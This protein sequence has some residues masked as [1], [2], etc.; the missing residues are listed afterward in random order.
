MLACEQ[1]SDNLK[2]P[3]CGSHYKGQCGS[4]TRATEVIRSVLVASAALSASSTSVFVSKELGFS[5][6]V[7]Y[8]NKAMLC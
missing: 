5:H 8:L 1:E 6:R 7:K 4:G 2:R 3:L